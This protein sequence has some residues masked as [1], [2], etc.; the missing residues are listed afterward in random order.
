MA[1]DQNL[2]QIGYNADTHEFRLI[3]DK[4]TDWVIFRSD[5]TPTDVGQKVKAY[6]EYT[7]KKD[8]KAI[9]GLEF[10]VKKTSPDGH[11]WLWNQDKKIGI[12]IKLL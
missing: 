7:V 2:C 8:T 5:A 12:I 3:N 6:L 1:Y 10:T 9:N 4:L 11:V